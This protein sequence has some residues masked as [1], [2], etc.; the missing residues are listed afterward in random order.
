M[1]TACVNALSGMAVGLMVEVDVFGVV[2]AVVPALADEPE[3]DAGAAITLAGTVSTP[4][5]GVYFTEVVSALDPAAAEADELNEVDAPA[6]VAPADP[7][8]WI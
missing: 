7:L 2:P 5:V 8:A 1:G 6:P 3:L 4:E